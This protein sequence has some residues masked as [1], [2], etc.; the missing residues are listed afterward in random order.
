LDIF[1]NKLVTGNGF[2]D[3]MKRIIIHSPQL[4]IGLNSEEEYTHI[5]NPIFVS[6]TENVTY[7]A[8]SNPYCEVDL[9]RKQD[10]GTSFQT[11]YG[12]TLLVNKDFHAFLDSNRNLRF[13]LPKLLKMPSD[14]IFKNYSILP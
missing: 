13:L 12:N 5:L 14:D 10:R 7:G 3:S 2:D 9:T 1:V 4:G 8:A 11:N 6:G